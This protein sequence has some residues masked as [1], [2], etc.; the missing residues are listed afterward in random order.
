MIFEPATGWTIDITK[1]ADPELG[2][3]QYYPLRVGYASTI[4]RK[5]GADGLPH[6]TVYL[7]VP[8]AAAAAYTA[9]SRVST[10]DKIKFGGRSPRL[11]LHLRGRS[12]IDQAS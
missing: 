10:L 1:W 4:L 7:D 5:A 11:T 3:M 8:N 12:I 9:M 2:E 6:L